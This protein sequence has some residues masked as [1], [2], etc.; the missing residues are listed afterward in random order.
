MTFSAT[1]CLLSPNPKQNESLCCLSITPEQL[2]SGYKYIVAYSSDCCGSS[3]LVVL[4]T[5]WLPWLIIADK[6]ERQWSLEV[7]FDVEV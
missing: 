6:L 4:T 3:K 5:E 7:C 1:L 2:A